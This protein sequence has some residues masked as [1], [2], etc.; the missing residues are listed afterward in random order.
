MNCTHKIYNS[1]Q[2]Y[3]YVE[4]NKTTLLE[5]VIALTC[6]RW[7]VPDECLPSFPLTLIVGVSLKPKPFASQI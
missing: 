5:I 1:C 6:V 4:T 7:S 3:Q 2:A